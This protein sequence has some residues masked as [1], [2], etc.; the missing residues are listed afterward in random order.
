MKLISTLTCNSSLQSTTLTEYDRKLHDHLN[1]KII[2]LN[3]K[4]F[5]IKIQNTS[6]IELYEFLLY[7]GY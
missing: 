5:M 7:F 3:A 2:S 6:V 1:R 4:L